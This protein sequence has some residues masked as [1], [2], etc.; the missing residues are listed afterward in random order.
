MLRVDTRGR[1]LAKRTLPFYST[2]E[3]NSEKTLVSKKLSFPYITAEYRVHFA[4]NTNRTLQVKFFH[5]QDDNAP[6]SGEPK[7]HNVFG[8]L[9][10]IG[11]VVGDDETVKISD[12][13]EIDHRD[14]YIKLYANNTDAFEHTIH[15][16]VEVWQIMGQLVG[17]EE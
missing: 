16:E 15:A 1:V 12:E 8:T 3:A 13:V 2:V 9:G 4:L 7:D 17:T 10:Q 5:A 6:S 14:S 11:Y